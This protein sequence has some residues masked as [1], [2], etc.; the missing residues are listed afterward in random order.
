M[1][2]LASKV[3]FLVVALSVMGCSSTPLDDYVNAPDPHY[4][5]NFTTLFK[6]LLRCLTAG[7][8]YTGYVFRMRSLQWLTERDSDRS[9]WEHW[10]VTCVP[11]VVRDLQLGSLLP[12]VT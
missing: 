11:D 5:F 10:V 1:A 9:I 12:G 4:S 2:L 6:G 3:A 7:N 8:G